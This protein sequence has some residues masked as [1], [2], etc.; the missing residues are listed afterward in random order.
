[1]PYSNLCF[2]IA[3]YSAHNRKTESLQMETN[4]PAVVGWSFKLRVRT[5]RSKGKE[6][7]P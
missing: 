7:F 3:G 6:V 5:F 4:G 2:P 1:M